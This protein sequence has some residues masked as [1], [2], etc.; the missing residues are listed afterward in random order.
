MDAQKGFYGQISR[1]TRPKEQARSTYDRVS[2]WY[3]VFA[4][5]EEGPRSAGLRKLGA[6]NGER[7][8]EIG[9]GTGH[10]ILTMARSVGPSGRV[11]GIDLSEGMLNVTRERVGMAGLSDRVEVRRG[12]AA[13]LP[14][15]AD[16]FDAIFMSFTLELF[17]TPEIPVVLRECRRVL[18]HGG[19]ICVVEMSK[20]GPDSA[21]LRLYEWAH[22][23]FPAYVDCRPI[24][25]REA[26]EDAGF[27]IV[28]TTTVSLWSLPGE[29][30]VAEKSSA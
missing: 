15:G 24:F 25:V 11:Y 4:R 21:L 30:V 16:F 26:V 7:I 22:R 27:R 1:V 8:L 12:D 14:F 2:R 3:D 10:A 23:T 13:D 29:I 19:R 20:R 28:D 18:R 6:K 5:V 17:D 9:F